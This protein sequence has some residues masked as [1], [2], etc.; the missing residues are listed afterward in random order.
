MTVTQN[1]FF[2]TRP[3]RSTSVISTQSSPL[4]S[5]VMVS[6]FSMINIIIITITVIIWHRRFTQF[7]WWVRSPR[8][9]WLHCDSANLRGYLAGCSRS[10]RHHHHY[11]HWCP[12]KDRRVVTS[13]RVVNDFSFLTHRQCPSESQTRS[14]YYINSH[15]YLQSYLAGCF[16]STNRPNHFKLFNKV[17]LYNTSIDLSSFIFSHFQ[18]KNCIMRGVYFSR[19]YL[20]GAAGSFFY[21]LFILSWSVQSGTWASNSVRKLYCSHLVQNHKFSFYE[22]QSLSHKLWLNLN[23]HLSRNTPQ[24]VAGGW[25]EHRQ[26]LRRHMRKSL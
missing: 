5:V 21:S 12:S 3:I 2:I 17:S 7:L 20:W 15:L 14:S 25:V 18:I 11:H 13:P 8:W 9:K 10:T 19:R 24:F 6:A 16:R 1:H 26:V 23:M 22:P 4:S